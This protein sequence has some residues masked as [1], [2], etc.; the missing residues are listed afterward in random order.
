MGLDPWLVQTVRAGLKPMVQYGILFQWSEA[1][2]SQIASAIW[3]YQ[4]P[5]TVR[6]AGKA[7]KSQ[8]GLLTEGP[9]DGNQ[10]MIEMQN[11]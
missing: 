6:S 1:I 2:K 4:T 11:T 5:P 8:I 10:N 7:V 9:K 3:L